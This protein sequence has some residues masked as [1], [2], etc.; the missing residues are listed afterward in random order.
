MEE[1][2]VLESNKIYRQILDGLRS[3]FKKDI[4]WFGQAKSYELDRLAESLLYFYPEPINPN[5]IDWFEKCE[6]E[7]LI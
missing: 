5:S 3:S 1:S 6:K 4:R 7:G 2:K